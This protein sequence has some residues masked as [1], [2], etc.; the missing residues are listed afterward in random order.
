M[1]ALPGLHG[2]TQGLPLHIFGCRAQCPGC[3]VQ[4]PLLGGE[5]GQ[6]PNATRVLHC[7]MMPCAFRTTTEIHGVVVGA[8]IGRPRTRN[9]RPYMLY[10][11][12]CCPHRALQN[13]LPP[14]K[15]DPPSP[16]SRSSHL[17]RRPRRK[18]KPLTDALY[19][20]ILP[21]PGPQIL[22]LNLNPTRPWV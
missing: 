5:L 20:A 11:V 12:E 8:A 22:F 14:H 9:A 1:F 18:R 6:W 4:I 17:F 10:I 2:Q 7:C 16:D 19:H 3:A 21:S 13:R 15:K